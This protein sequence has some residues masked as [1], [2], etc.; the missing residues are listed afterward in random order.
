VPG[1]D[2]V[3]VKINA[4]VLIVKS[5]SCRWYV[6]RLMRISKIPQRARA[7]QRVLTFSALFTL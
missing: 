7:P 1:E 2:T 4:M 5:A 6:L 3:R